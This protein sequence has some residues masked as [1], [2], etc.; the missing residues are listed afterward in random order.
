MKFWIKIQT[1]LEVWGE[2]IKRWLDTHLCV[3]SRSAASQVVRERDMALEQ[4]EELE[5]EMSEEIEKL[6]NE[7]HY[8]KDE[9]S[10]EHL[11]NK[12]LEEEVQAVRDRD[13]KDIYPGLQ[14]AIN[15]LGEENREL[16]QNFSKI[17][18]G[19]KDFFC[20]KCKEDCTKEDGRCPFKDFAEFIDM[21]IKDDEVPT[22]TASEDC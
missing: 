4:L 9:L 5:D 1:T 20:E 18:E 12:R 11:R 15:R 19:A 22:E 10:Y 21:R 16:R 13:F 6:T 7:T 3:I 14:A 17:V 2:A 8:L